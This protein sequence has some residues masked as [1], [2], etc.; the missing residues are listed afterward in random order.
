MTIDVVN[1]NPRD[2]SF[3]NF[4][5]SS[6]FEDAPFKNTILKIIFEIKNANDNKG[7]QTSRF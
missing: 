3:H 7:S 6:Y 4:A 1:N 5:A 2:K